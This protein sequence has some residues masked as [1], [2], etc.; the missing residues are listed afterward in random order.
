MDPVR[1][2]G[3]GFAVQTAGLAYPLLLT[4][5]FGMDDINKRN[6]KFGM[7]ENRHRYMVFVTL[8]LTMIIL[9]GGRGRSD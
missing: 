7:V 8:I 3:Y 4:G 1:A 6:E 2:L 9:R 5:R